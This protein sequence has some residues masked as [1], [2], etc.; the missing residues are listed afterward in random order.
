[1]HEP[2]WNGPRCLGLSCGRGALE[3]DGDLGL[4]A[5]VAVVVVPALIL[6]SCAGYAYYASTIR[7]CTV[8][9]SAT[10]ES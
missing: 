9:G 3:I 6:A 2:G 10:K 1:M 7:P 4:T 5:L 8:Q